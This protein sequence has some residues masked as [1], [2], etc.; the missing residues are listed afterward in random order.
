MTAL[1]AEFADP[2]RLIAAARRTRLGGI[3]VLDAFTPFPLDGLAEALDLRERSVQPFGFL[4]LVLGALFG[5]G[6]QVFA[7]SSYPL[8]IG[9]RPILAVPAF[10]VLTFEFAMLGAAT[11]VFFAMLAL[12]RLPRL[13][14]PVFEAQH[15]HLASRDRFFLL[16]ETADEEARRFVE[17]LEP[18]SIA[19]VAP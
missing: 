15:F 16:I 4:G 1:L 3:R 17:G 12:N 13:H 6:I 5:W 10:M 8:D 11:F 14:H 19:E 18:V 9:G 2:A 7:I